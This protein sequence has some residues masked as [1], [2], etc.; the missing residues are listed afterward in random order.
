MFNMISQAE[1]LF[2]TSIQILCDL[3]EANKSLSESV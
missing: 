1:S 3:S 2:K